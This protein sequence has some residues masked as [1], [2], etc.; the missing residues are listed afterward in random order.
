LVAGAPIVVGGLHHNV[1]VGGRRGWLFAVAICLAVVL[2]PVTGWLLSA[3]A[4]GAEIANVLTMPVSLLA[5]F[6]AAVAILPL[7]LPV[8]PHEGSDPSQAPVGARVQDAFAWIR[9][10][11]TVK[12]AL[13]VAVLVPLMVI[14]VLF[15]DQ[16][17]DRASV[18]AFG[19]EH[20][21]QLRVLTSP[22]QLEP[23]RQL[24][25]GYARW[26]AKRSYGCAVVRAYVFAPPPKDARDGLVRWSGTTLRDVG[27]QPDVWLAGS[28][29]EVDKVVTAAAELGVES[30]ITHDVAIAWSPVVVGIP[31][32]SAAALEIPR[33]GHPWTG[34][35]RRVTELGWDVVRP[36]PVTSPVGELST[37]LL[38]KAD[39]PRQVEQRLGR[40][41]DDGGYP[42]GDGLDVLCRYRQLDPARTAVIVS[43]QELVRFNRGDPL[44]GDCRSREQRREGDDVLL[45]FYPS[46]TRAVEHRFVRFGWSGPP[47]ATQAEAFG[48]WLAAADGK[49]A[50][51][52]AGLRPPDIAA[53]DPLNEQHGVLPEAA[54]QHDPIAPDALDQALRVYDGAQRRGRVL[55]ALDGSGSMAA[56]AGHDQGSRFDVAGRGI[57]RA[58]E[59]MGE[60][61]EFGLWIF[62][63]D[64]GGTGAREAVPIGPRNGPVGDAP[65]RQATDGA[66]GQVQPRGNTPLYRAIV[67]GVR[68]VGPSDDDRISA[69]VVLTDGEDTSSGLTP[70]QVYDA[71]GKAGVR[72]FVVAVGEAT[73]AAV[74]LDEVAAVTG[75]RCVDANVRSID[76]EL[77]GIF[78]ALWS[79]VE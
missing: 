60:R 24:A 47:Q 58:L 79:V 14:G 77:A 66:L 38:Y 44:G 23:A 15:G 32:P 64:P 11:L 6:C 8:R 46:D 4:R 17:R 7:W 37:A 18:W 62:P 34:F 36:D 19:C 67:D 69:L 33:H 30:P 31:A 26:A 54:F 40:S 74:A 2:I 49:R 59:L 48:S 63:G 28:A 39:D 42:L 57:V 76:A 5:L 45:A 16:L 51:L 52:A 12:V 25:D 65:R 3:G 9:K 70:A 68:A 61:D 78:G 35:F 53:T 27:P 1:G 21:T 72:V 75:G 56:P 29:S 43:E 22:E 73:C 20:P 55:L 50:L 41:L 71:V 13:T 10:R